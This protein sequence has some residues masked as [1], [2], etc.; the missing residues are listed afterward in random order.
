LDARFWI[1]VAPFIVALVV[2]FLAD[3]APRLGTW[4]WLLGPAAYGTLFLLLGL[5]A[6]GYSARLSWSGKDFANRYGMEEMRDVYRAAFLNQLPPK[7]L[8][9]E[10]Q[11]AL[12]MLRRFEPLARDNSGSVNR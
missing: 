12:Q 5:A 4:P 10:E 7:Q 2:G 3:R 6:L 8:N 9:E 11:H 1:P